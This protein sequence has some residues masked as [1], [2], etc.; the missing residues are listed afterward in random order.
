MP[1]I[2]AVGTEDALCYV[3]SAMSVYKYG[4]QPLTGPTRG[5]LINDEVVRYYRGI[6]KSLSE[7]DPTQGTDGDIGY[8]DYMLLAIMLAQGLRV[9]CSYLATWK[10]EHLNRRD[11]EFRMQLVLGNG[12]E[13]TNA[14][15]A[16]LH[17]K[18][19]NS[20][21][22][23]AL[24]AYEAGSGSFHGVA[25]VRHANGSAKVVDSHGKGSVGAPEL[26]LPR[27]H[28]IAYLVFLYRR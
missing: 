17:A 22:I 25:I 20:K 26:L 3:A 1:R 8:P 12:K 5:R 9:R 10:H 27:R 6:L 13:I 11:S 19:R 16:R 24:L 4:V 18:F 14:F 15:I 23:G 28:A 7:S 2:R 21:V